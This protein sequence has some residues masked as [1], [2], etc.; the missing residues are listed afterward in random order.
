MV[1]VLA[2]GPAAR[3]PAQGV[4]N[5]FS[6]DNLRLSGIQLDLGVLGASELTGAVVGGL[7]VDYGLIAPRVRVLLG[8]SY[9]RSEFDRAARTRF[10]QRIRALV[11]DPDS[12]F[13][14]DVSWRHMG[15]GERFW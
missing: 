10:E 15:E 8:L 1:L 11:D 2:V 3:L 9:V 6:Y 12:N 7:R 14:V 13:T 4:L 5:Q